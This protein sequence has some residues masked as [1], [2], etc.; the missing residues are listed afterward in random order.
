M[1]NAECKNAD[2]TCREGPISGVAP[3]MHSWRCMADRSQDIRDG[4]F[5]SACR[6]AHVALSLDQGPGIRCIVDQLLESG[7][8][9]GA[10]LEE[11]KAGSTTRDFEHRVETALREARRSAN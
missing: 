11:A 3:R 2:G 5:E 10:N 9:I 4:T 8:S 6:I 1:Q 7:T